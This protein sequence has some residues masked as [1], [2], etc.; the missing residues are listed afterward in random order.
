MKRTFASAIIVSYTL[1][2]LPLLAQEMPDT[3]KAKEGEIRGS[4]GI[5]M[6]AAGGSY[7]IVFPVN[8]PWLDTGVD[9][10]V[11]DVVTIIAV[12]SKKHPPCDG[13]TACPPYRAADAVIADGA[14]GKGLTAVVGRIGAEGTAFSV[15]KEF[16]GTVS[17][18]GRLSIG[19]NDCWACWAD[20]TGA[21]EVTITVTTK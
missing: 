2:A 18:P 8:T 1:L 19:Y 13:R 3:S 17:E 9:V 21:F 16:I 10:A 12:P 14:L 15:G 7:L 20:N 6:G 5:G 4:V 11:G